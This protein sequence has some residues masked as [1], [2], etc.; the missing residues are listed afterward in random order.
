MTCNHNTPSSSVIH[1]IQAYKDSFWQCEKRS[2][3]LPK[4]AKAMRN[5]V[6][7][8]NK[9]HNTARR[10]SVSRTQTY[11]FRLTFCRKITAKGFKMAQRLSA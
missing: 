7:Y 11:I 10:Q 4:V 3:A 2:F 1:P 8:R 6:S 9:G 5:A